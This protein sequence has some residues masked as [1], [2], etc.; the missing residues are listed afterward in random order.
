MAILPTL[1]TISNLIYLNLPLFFAGVTLV[2]FDELSL[3]CGLILL[4]GL[5]L[6]LVLLGLALTSE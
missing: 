2:L 3:W 5:S 1:P 4:L 6:L